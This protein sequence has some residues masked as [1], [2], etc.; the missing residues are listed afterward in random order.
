MTAYLTLNLSEQAVDFTEFFTELNSTSPV[1]NYQI[2]APQS[3]CTFE[4]WEMNIERA[5]TQIGT[6][7]LRKVVLANAIQLTFENLISA[8]DLVEQSRAINLGCYHFMGRKCT[9]CFC[10]LNA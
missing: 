2:S 10:G 5:I 7:D 6:G 1:K 3:S 9:E 4:Q 8:Y